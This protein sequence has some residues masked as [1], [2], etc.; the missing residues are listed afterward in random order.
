MIDC[1]ERYSPRRPISPSAITA[2]RPL[3]EEI[4]AVG[5]ERYGSVRQFALAAGISE[6]ALSRLA[7]GKHQSGNVDMLAKTLAALP[8]YKVVSR[9]GELRLLPDRVERRRS[10]PPPGP[11]SPTDEVILAPPSSQSSTSSEGGC[12]PSAQ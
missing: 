5:A 6:A 1:A 12:P 9:G 8:D 11:A 7:S 3:F 10:T 4:V 2:G